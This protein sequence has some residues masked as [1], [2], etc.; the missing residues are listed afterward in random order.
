[1]W[2]DIVIGEGNKGN[3]AI[4]CRKGLMYSIA[5]NAVSYWISSDNSLNIGLTIFKYT[6]QG[7]G[8]ELLIKQDESNDIIDNYVTEVILQNITA[9]KFHRMLG[10]IIERSIDKGKRIKQ[11]EF[12][13]VLGL[14]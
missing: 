12:Q 13:K 10:Y 2:D 9:Y 4:N 7:Q 5:Q 14:N 3:T 6:N 11:E 1:M 8:L